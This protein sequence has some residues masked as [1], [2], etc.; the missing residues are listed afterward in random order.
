MVATGTSFGP[1]AC[2]KLGRALSMGAA[3][4]LAVAGSAA[5]GSPAV[6]GA[7]TKTTVS[8]FTAKP[9]SL[10]WA[11]GAVTLSA[12]VA[13]AK[14][15]TFSVTPSIKGL[16][17]KKT[18]TS[19]TVDEKVTVPKNTGTKAITYTF[20]LSVTGTTTV[21]ATP[22]KTTV[23]V[24]PPPT[25]SGFGAAPSSLSWSGGAVTLSAQVTNAKSCVFSSSP[26]ISGLPSTV[27]CTSG[28]VTKQVTV[29]AN[30]ETNA[31]VYTF[32]LSVTG[33]TTV[34]AKPTTVTVGA[35]S[36]LTGVSSVASDGVGYCAVLSSGGV[37]C[38]GENNVGE[39]GNGTIDGPDVDLDYDTPQTVTGISN[40]VSVTSSPDAGTS[41][42]ALLSTGGIDCW[43]YND[44]GQLG[45]GT[46]GGPD[47]EGGY[48]TPQT[49]TGITDAASVVSDADSVGFCAVL[50]TGGV[51]CWGYNP[52][53][54]L[55]NGTTGGPDGQEGYDSPQA[56]TGITDA[57]SVTPDG[58]G[59]C[60]VL[61]TGGVDCWGYNSVGELGNGAY[62]GPDGEYGYDTPQPVS[63]ITDADSVTTDFGGYCAV[64]STGGVDCWGDNSRGQLGIGTTS[65]PAGEYGYDTPQPVTGI[66][67]ALSL[68]SGYPSTGGPQEGY[69]AVLS[70]GGVDC[71]G[72]NGSGEIGNGTVG[73]TDGEDGYDTPQA[74]T[75]ITDA[76]S[77]TSDYD[78]DYNGEGISHCAVL[79][80]GGLDC[81]GDNASGQLG[82]GTTGG[83]DGE[84]G[85]DTPQAASGITDAASVTTD[86]T[87]YCAVLSTGGADCWGYNFDGEVG[88]GT[89]NGPDAKYDYDTPQAVSSQ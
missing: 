17:A 18:C 30:A 28:K 22:A 83:P 81:W 46:T 15:C 87:G 24:G 45:N 67:D 66:N 43:G 62:N 13:N 33:K 53:G 89:T 70:T 86:V 11:G 69:C 37:D 63:G 78:S 19:G 38:W 21:K 49:V 74:V 42:C 14:T 35:A 51:D 12:K 41:Y 20:G 56:V 48:D 7:A 27:S 9:S 65:E 32:N 36:P 47:G 40:A 1:G 75:G 34:A 60:A 55:G 85:Y 71:W 50:T 26:A 82:N 23:G 79:S 29:R 6:A 44:S 73:G 39:L 16:P 76:V 88:N 25:V 80:T 68:T 84:G 57:D 72:D 52:Y 59:Y 64:L 58:S 77:A 3:L 2:R 54:E 5:F 61:S 10:T 31:V 4:L 8:S